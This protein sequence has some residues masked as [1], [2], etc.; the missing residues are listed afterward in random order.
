MERETKIYVLRDP[1]THAVRYVGKT[2]QS[3]ARRLN[4]H[5]HRSDAKKTHRDC[6]I[7]GL[8]MAGLIPV[9]ECVATAGAD[10]AECEQF[11]IAHY[12]AAGCDLTNQTDGGEGTPGIEV[13]DSVRVEMSRR[14]IA[15]MTPEYRKQLSEKVKSGW[16]PERRAEWAAKMAER[17]T[18]EERARRSAQQNAPEM[19]ARQREKQKEV[20]T[21]ERRAA[22]AAQVKAQMTPERIAAHKERLRKT[23]S[24]PEWKARH[25]VSQ[26]AK[27]TPEMR[28]AQAARTRAQFAAKR[29]L[30]Q[31]ESQ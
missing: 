31:S 20:W 18:P 30:T 13:K 12:R 10:W 17:Q 24:D 8:R 11:W 6:W 2:V 9:I 5:V 21:P 27:W 25:S 4:A 29:A 14:Q 28:A 1:R 7:A 16:T 19:L 23:T 15:K 3:L 22:R 26:R